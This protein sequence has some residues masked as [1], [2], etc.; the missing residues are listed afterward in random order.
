MNR[1]MMDRDDLSSNEFNHSVGEQPRKLM[2]RKNKR[3]KAFSKFEYESDEIEKN[4]QNYKRA[5]AKYATR[6]QLRSSDII[7]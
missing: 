2:S 7:N 6:L 4:R 5:S 3:V 1:N